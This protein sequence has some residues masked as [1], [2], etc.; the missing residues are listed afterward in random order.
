[1]VLNF[2]VET[3]I[4]G[5]KNIHLHKLRSLL[6]TLGIVFGVAAVIVMVAIGEGTKRQSL[7]EISKLGAQNIL[8]RS[9][10]PPEGTS[11]SGR[12]QKILVYGIKDAD[13]DRIRSLPGLKYAV[14]LRDTQQKVVLGDVLSHAQP[15]GVLPEIFEVINLRP[16]RGRTFD[17]VDVLRKA[18]VC[19]LGSLACEQLF[20]FENPIGQKIQIGSAGTGIITLEI[21]G[22]LEKT[23]L[24]PGAGIIERVLDLDIYMPLSVAE[25]AWGH[26]NTKFMP[27]GAREVKQIELTEIWLQTETMDDVEATAKRV[28]NILQRSHEGS[29][30]YEVKVPLDMLRN[31]EATA[32]RFN[33]I[34]GGIAS[35]ALIVGGIGIMNIMLASVTERTREIGIRRAL[36]AKRRH[37]TL[38]FLIETTLVSLAGGFIGVAIGVSGAIALPIVMRAF[39]SEQVYP[40]SITPWSVLGSFIISGIIGVGF[41]LYPAVMAAKM[42]PIEA[43]RHE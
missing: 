23:G 11:A 26:N 24:R 14:P 36:G 1:M 18:Q 7:E 21:I 20:P 40:T 27:S 15:I 34:L 43:L 9:V 31:A 30:D 8:I 28:Q 22:V 38:Q 5:V 2:L 39:G 12:T 16:E 3:F 42:D 35:F 33:F 29:A 4:L 37:I 10:P 32:R 13:L 41:G 6:T 17:Q 19:V 25:A